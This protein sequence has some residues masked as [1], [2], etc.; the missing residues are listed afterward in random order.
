MEYDSFIKEMDRRLCPDENFDIVKRE[1]IIGKREAALY[2]TD[3]FIKDEVYEK[4]LEF[5]FSITSEQLAEI[6]TMERFK[7][8]KMPYVEVD[9]TDSTDE[10]V[11]QVLSGAS[12]LAIEGVSGVLLADTRT[13]PSRSIEEP[14][15]DKSLRGSRDGF[16]EAL[17]FNTSMIRRRI[18]S[19]NLRMEYHRISSN[20]KLDSAICY[21]KGLAREKDIERIRERLKSIKIKSVSMTQQA[22]S[23][24]FCGK[25]PLN[26]LPK[27]R[28]TERPDFAA[29]A[30]L[31]GKI[32]LIVDNMPSVILLPDSF[33]DFFRETDDYYFSPIIGSYTR[34]LRM[35]VSL[36]TVTATPLYILLASNP[37]YIPKWLSFIGDSGDYSIPLLAQFLIL[38]LVT[39]GLRIAS[40]NTPD[41][42]SSSLGIIG[43]LL[44]SEFAVNAGW[45]LGESILLMAFVTIASYTQP[46][47]EMGY[48]MKFERIFILVLTALFDLYGFVIGIVACIT[49]AAFNKT[50]LGGGYLYPII[51][52]NAK[53]FTELFIRHPIEK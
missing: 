49:L 16:I 4:M 9:D 29:A 2:F 31:D 26:P 37:D 28:F 3:G 45:F 30:I 41:S 20:S 24:A 43:G 39:D 22:I 5:L 35:F 15:K 11:L 13:Y 7:K 25:H 33:A 52:F 1:L 40:L 32:A 44:L 19:E 46:S 50:V 23:E 36:F 14:Q 27:L 53:A 8:N 48:A 42:I 47:F 12:V 34:I 51:P 6:K 38:E 17:V 21:I 18:R 10:A